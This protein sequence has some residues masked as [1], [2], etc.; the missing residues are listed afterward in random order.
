MD[1]KRIPLLDPSR[2][3]ISADAAQVIDDLMRGTHGAP[4]VF[5][6]SGLSIWEPSELP[7]GQD[8]TKAMFS[9]LFGDFLASSAAERALLERVFGKEWSP[10][11]SGM[12]FEHLMECC[13]S[14]AKANALVNRLYN[15]RS[16]NALHRA[17]AK[18]LKQGKIHSIITTNY[19]CCLDEALTAERC[20]FVKAVTPEQA[21]A[22]RGAVEPRYFKIHGSV[23]G[24][25]ETSPMFTLRHEGL[26][27]PH[28][29][30]LLADL[31]EGRPLIM[32][33]YSGLDFELCP[34]IERLQLAN[35]VWNNLW[36][37]YPS[38]SAERLIR[39]KD[40]TLLYG[41][42]RDLLGRWLSLADRPEMVPSKEADVR[43][44]VRELFDEG[45]LAMWRVRVLNS[46][47]LASFTLKALGDADESPA[48]VFFNVERGR[49]EFHSGRYKRS[50]RRFQR[51]FMQALLA[52]EWH[53]AADAALETSDAYRSYGAPLR[54]YA[55][56][57][58]VPLFAAR[59]STAKKLL[60]QSLIVRDLAEVTRSLRELL[61][62]RL[63]A[64]PLVDAAA[65]ALTEI[66]LRVMGG[67][68]FKCA[69]EALQAG[70]W[71][72]FQQVSLIAEGT[73]VPIPWAS[74][75]YP[76]PKAAEG[77]RHLGYYIP[78]AMVFTSECLKNRERLLTS[79]EARREWRRHVKLCRLLGL[80][81]ALW[82][83]LALRHSPK[84][85]AKAREA[86]AR[87]E[88]GKLKGS[89]D[90]KKYSE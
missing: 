4:T 59:Q 76:P 5:A 65:R 28:K 6:G 77:Y 85:K 72:D 88:Y 30:A 37:Y 48:R 67:K 50:R 71:I 53:G 58:A 24:R 49:A 68:L 26:L 17:L 22:A 21:L 1:V 81:A 61:R 43:A 46:L 66:L 29:R 11:F 75:F 63:G 41:D 12:P 62:S 86:F 32:L 60:K 2:R 52:L 10:H 7:S 42:M 40:G 44:A 55:C 27:H 15:S 20:P 45:E 87:C 35:L 78:Q 74:E 80:D 16:P 18:G 25:L 89:L 39:G 84:I 13:P 23:E 79:P 9:V 82:K 8:F 14:E 31:V 64:V 3:C 33:G 57:W 36:D 90:W 83:V 47:G 70:N 73:N 34:E 54:A 56:T 51:A 69:S 38:V 19:D